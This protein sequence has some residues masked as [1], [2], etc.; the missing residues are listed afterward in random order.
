MNHILRPM[1]FGFHNDRM[2]IGYR[3]TQLMNKRCN[4]SV[5]LH[6]WYYIITFEH[7]LPYYKWHFCYNHGHPRLS[8]SHLLQILP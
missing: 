6:A 2:E 3:P 4:L 1:A 5:R 7:L 8:I